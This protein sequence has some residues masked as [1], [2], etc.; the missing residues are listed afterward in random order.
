TNRSGIINGGVIGG[1]AQAGEWRIDA[2]FNKVELISR[3]EKIASYSSRI[4]VYNLD[5]CDFLTGIMP[6]LPEKSLIYLDPPYFEKGNR[7]YHSHYKKN[8]H[9]GL[10]TWI[11]DHV[12]HKW[13]VSYDDVPE[14]DSA[15]SDRRKLH[16]QI[17]YSARSNYSG[18]EIM[19][20]S[21]NLAIPNILNPLKNVS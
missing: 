18:S 11:Q 16:Y 12:K 21:D 5:V 6:T 2:R 19:I 15:Y 3:I 13:L 8:D 14:I 20:Y 10:A 1:L 4:S 7:L 9:Q 17:G